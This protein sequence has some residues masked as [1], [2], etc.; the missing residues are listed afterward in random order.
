MT[1]P[2]L[3]FCFNKWSES[4]F[5]ILIFSLINFMLISLEKM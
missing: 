4:K 3:I 1:F 2:C 5:T